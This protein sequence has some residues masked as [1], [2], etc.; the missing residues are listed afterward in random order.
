MNNGSERRRLDPLAL[1]PGFPSHPLHPPLTDA[2]ISM[3]L[4]VVHGVVAATTLV[5]LLRSALK[6]EQS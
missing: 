5:L 4:I 1:T 6:L 2:M 3:D